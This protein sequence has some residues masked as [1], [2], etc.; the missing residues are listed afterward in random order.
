MKR[1]LANI[2]IL[3]IIILTSATLHAQEK[4]IYMD[5]EQKIIV[6]DQKLEKKLNLFPEK[7]GFESA[8]LFQ[9]N[10]DQFVLEITTEKHDFLERERIDMN[11]TE[12]LAFQQKLEADLTEKVPLAG[13]DQSGRLELMVN[14]TAV[15]LG[16][17]G[18]AMPAMLETNEAS[19]A[20]GAYMLTSAAGFFLPFKMTQNREITKGQASMYGYGA[21]RGIVH[22]LAIGELISSDKTYDMRG[23]LALGMGFSVAEGIAGYHLAKKY[24][25]DA[26]TSAAVGTYT[27]AGMIALPL[28]MFAAGPEDIESPKLLIAS[29]LVGAAGG[30]MAGK[31]MTDMQ[32]YS[33]GDAH[34][35]KI[36]GLMG[37]ALPI[38]IGG[39]F[40]IDK[41]RL[42]AAASVAGGIAGLGIGHYVTSKYDFT[43]GQGVYFALGS[44]AGTG[45]GAGTVFVLNPDGDGKAVLAGAIAGGVGGYL[46]M[47]KIL[48]KRAP[49]SKDKDIS[50]NMSL[51]PEGFAA[52]MGNQAASPTHEFI[53][54]TPSL[55]NATIRF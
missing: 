55:V 36:S 52:A 35:L 47:N 38:A 4:Q 3:L 25:W 11:R 45:I 5:Q 10:E 18:W 54:T 12:L 14:A 30:F 23:H 16:Y 29:S 13:V 8:R 51:N 53:K 26:G 44:I 49:L 1:I 34:I 39:I 15:S 41:P 2:T 42:G 40:E 20:V 7:K 21:T 37:A 17:Y 32:S 43:G 19:A 33:R 48:S 6:I 9:T 50:F 24:N 46:T 28:I 31:K 22:G 27:D